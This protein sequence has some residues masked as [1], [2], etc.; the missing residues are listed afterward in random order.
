MCMLEMEISYQWM[1]FHLLEIV[2]I[3]NA[4]IAVLQQP[5]TFSS[6]FNW[7]NRNVPC[8]KMKLWILLQKMAGKILLR[9][10]NYP[11]EMHAN[12]A[13]CLQMIIYNVCE[14]LFS[15]LC[16]SDCYYKLVEWIE[17]LILLPIYKLLICFECIWWLKCRNVCIIKQQDL[18]KGV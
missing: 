1:I 18:S 9:L 14:T 7:M 5:P 6:S 13:K 12:V 11:I 4:K 8:L 15:S 3:S 2:V 10:Y 17:L 16:W